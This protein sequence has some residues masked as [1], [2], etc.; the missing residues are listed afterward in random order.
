MRVTW[1]P[2]LQSIVQTYGTFSVSPHFQFEIVYDNEIFIDLNRPI[3]L[4][5]SSAFFPAWETKKSALSSR[6]MVA[7]GRKT[8][9]HYNRFNRFFFQLLNYRASTV[10]KNVN[11]PNCNSPF[12]FL[13]D[14]Y[15][16]D[17]FY[18]K[19]TRGTRSFV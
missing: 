16:L 10:T 7:V 1:P 2:P 19:V 5:Y 14:N 3:H 13:N 9:D 15:P 18:T 11:K 12:A 4:L 6:S 8:L 17:L